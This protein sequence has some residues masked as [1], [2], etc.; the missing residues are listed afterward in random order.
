MTELTGVP[1]PSIDW[2][3]GNLPE[4]LRI[5][6]RT[7]QY[8]FNGPLAAKD[9]AVKVQYLMLWV[10]ED[11]HDICD[12]WALSDENEKLLSPHWRGFEEYAKPKSSFRVSRFQ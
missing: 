3:T 8:R 11:G 12:G 5:S 10:G 6:K 2:H 4:T 9:E 1:I 7:C